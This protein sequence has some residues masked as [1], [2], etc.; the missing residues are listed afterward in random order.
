MANH[1][2]PWLSFATVLNP[3]V[4]TRVP[5]ID[6]QHS[7]GTSHLVVRGWAVIPH[8]GEVVAAGPS[9]IVATALAIG[10]GVWVWRHRASVTSVSILWFMA[11][12]LALRCLFE[13][14]MSPYYFV[15]PLLMIVLCA[16][17]SRGWRFCT[18]GLLALAISVYSDRNFSP[19]VWYLPL[20]VLLLGSLAVAAPKMAE[21]GLSRNSR[22]RQPAAAVVG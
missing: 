12:S 18:A 21:L 2:T 11:A 9:R 1:T 22:T 20:V 19:W 16:S 15:P 7:H 17:L 3:G 4:T 6:V 10:I 14:V 5:I 8:V 13:P